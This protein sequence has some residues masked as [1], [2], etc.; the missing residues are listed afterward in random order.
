MGETPLFPYAYMRL[1]NVSA[2][3]RVSKPARDD[4]SLVLHARERVS[5]KFPI[6]LGSRDKVGA[7]AIE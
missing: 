2:R 6:G 1:Q 7:A 3:K 5:D 4:V